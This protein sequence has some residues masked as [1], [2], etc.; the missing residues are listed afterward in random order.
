MHDPKHT[1]GPWGL[2][3]SSDARSK[4]YIRS[5]AQA[6]PGDPSGRPAICRITPTGHSADTTRANTRL[7]EAA[8]DLLAACERLLD[9]L[10]QHEMLHSARLEPQLV[11]GGDLVGQ[12]RSAAKKAGAIL[13]EPGWWPWK[14]SPHSTGVCMCGQTPIYQ[15]DDRLRCDNCVPR[16]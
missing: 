7:I 10:T 13:M 14:P 15:K 2:C 8:P 12:I 9:R 1:R 6:R 3:D 16:S 5:C 11:L 4:G